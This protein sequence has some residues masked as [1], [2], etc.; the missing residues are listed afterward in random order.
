MTTMLLSYLYYMYE[1]ISVVGS[2]VPYSSAKNGRRGKFG[3]LNVKSG[4]VTG[5]R[6]KF[7]NADTRGKCK[8]STI[9]VLDLP[10]WLW[11]EC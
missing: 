4:E 8:C 2:Y 1:M 7:V 5:A 11:K 6:F 10:P 9:S 3:I